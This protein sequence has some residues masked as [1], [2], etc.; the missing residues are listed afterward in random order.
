MVKVGIT[1]L[2]GPRLQTLSTAMIG[3]LC[4][5]SDSVFC[6]KTETLIFLLRF[7]FEHF[8][9]ALS[10]IAAKEGV[11][12]SPENIYAFLIDRVR[13]NL[14]VVLAMSPVGEPFRF[15]YLLHILCVFLHI[16]ISERDRFSISQNSVL[17]ISITFDGD[18]MPHF[19]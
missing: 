16:H 3:F 6:S 13:A 19:R 5:D 11:H 9:T 1:F 4:N 12:D 7:A 18:T 2:A 17:L 14:H 15:E 8:R 10:D